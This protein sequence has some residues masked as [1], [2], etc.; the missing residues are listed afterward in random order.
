VVAPPK[1]GSLSYTKQSPVGEIVPMEILAGQFPWAYCLLAYSLD[2]IVNES[3]FSVFEVEEK[4]GEFGSATYEACTSGASIYIVAIGS[5][6]NVIP[7]AVS[8]F[9]K[10]QKNRSAQT[11]GIRKYLRP[12]KVLLD[13]F[14][15]EFESAKLG[16]S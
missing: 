1:F 14:K 13:L 7:C 16:I 5:E 8:I 3:K 10:S 4:Y 15:W 11:G 12:L 6:V 2:V 9:P